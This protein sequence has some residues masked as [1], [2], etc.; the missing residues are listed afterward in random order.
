MKII[1]SRSSE[2]NSEK[3]IVINLFDAYQEIGSTLL[4]KDAN[5]TRRV[6]TSPIMSKQTKRS[7]L[8]R[9]TSHWR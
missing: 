9:K 1:G 8:I 6:L 2:N 3:T 5:V 4:S 7:H